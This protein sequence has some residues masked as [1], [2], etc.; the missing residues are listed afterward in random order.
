[1]PQ[2]IIVV[3]AGPVGSLAALYAAV[4]GHNVEVYELRP[5]GFSDIR[6]ARYA[7]MQLDLRDPNTTPLN[8]SKSINL[9][10]SERGIHSL[11][12]TGLSDLADAVLAE[13]FPMHGRMI[14]VRKNGEYVRQPQIYDARGRVSPI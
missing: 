11:R 1:M 6:P 13:T 9:A 3:G 7:L 10:L 8:F 5:G 4:R 14:H 12:Q 2:K